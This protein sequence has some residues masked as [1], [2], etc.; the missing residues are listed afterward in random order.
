MPLTVGLALA[1]HLDQEVTTLARLLRVTRR[2]GS[3]LRFTDAVEPVVFEGFTYRADVSFTCSA[4]LTSSV[5][6][7][8]QSVT[9]DAV[10]DQD[11]FREGDLRRR[12]YDKAT[13]EVLVV[14][15][16]DPSMGALSKFKGTVGQIK[17]TDKNRVSIE[18]VTAGRSVNGSVAYEKYS[19]NCRASLGDARCKVDI[20][21]LKVSI[22]VN[23]VSGQVVGASELTQADNFWMN[24]FIKW[25]S[26]ANSGSTQPIVSSNQATNSLTLS[27]QV[28]EGI[29]AGDTA[30]VF[31]GCDRTVATC[32]TV[33]DNILNMRAEPFV[34]TRATVTYEGV[35]DITGNFPI[36]PG[37]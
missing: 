37:T 5:M 13:A 19:A 34:P 24:G 32:K 25:T 8:A 30:D 31:P 33:Y 4:I 3:V 29:V 17:L 6:T 12:L 18:V 16:E 20:E 36:V 21:A 11:G 10:M 27:G 23:A 14:N 22:T 28:V 26:G 15:Y 1:T 35:V 7:N 2:D 9:I